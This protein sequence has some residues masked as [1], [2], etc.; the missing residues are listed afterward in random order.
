MMLLVTSLII[1]RSL[2]W[3]EEAF[4]LDIK[5]WR[6]ENGLE[7][8]I[9]EDHAVP[10]VT[11]QVWY[12]VGSRNERPGTTGIS[13]FLEH[14]MFKG[15]PKYGPGLYT[16][17]IQ[18]YGGTQNAF[19]SYD[20]TAYYSVLPSARLE[21]ALDLEADRMAHLL[22]DPNEIKAEREVVKEERRLRENSPNGADVR[23]VGRLGLQGSPLSL[24]DHRL[25]E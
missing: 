15:T 3:A 8:L 23:G 25:D 10:L 16:Q 12:R 9:L 2:G 4:H 14:M 13:H 21:L 1:G 19:T 24:A 18:R 6:L 7:V 11:V 22:L 17:L 20:M 5:E